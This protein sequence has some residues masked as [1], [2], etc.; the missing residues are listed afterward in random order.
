MP[1]LKHSTKSTTPSSLV[2]ESTGKSLL[3]LFESY[4]TDRQLM[5]KYDAA[6]SH[7][8]PVLTSALQGSHLAPI[9]LT[10]LLIGKVTHCKFLMFA[11]EL[12]IFV[13]V[14][15]LLDVFKGK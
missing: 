4:L 15:S 9:S 5:V 3:R 2:L 12:K 1:T 10:C 13:E 8:F 7:P 14:H 11:D 6:I